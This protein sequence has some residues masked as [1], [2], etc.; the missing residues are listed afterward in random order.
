ML[1]IPTYRRHDAH[2]IC[3]MNVFIPKIVRPLACSSGLVRFILL[4]VYFFNS[5]IRYICSPWQTPH[6]RFERIDF[7]RDYEISTYQFNV[8]AV[9]FF[10][11]RII[12]ATVF[13]G[14]GLEFPLTSV[15]P[16]SLRSA[17]S[18]SSNPL[19]SSVNTW[20]S[21]TLGSECRGKSELFFCG[22]RGQSI[23][24]KSI[25]SCQ[26]ARTAQAGMSRCFCFLFF[27]LNFPL[28]EGSFCLGIVVSFQTRLNF[29]ILYKE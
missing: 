28:V 8:S 7:C 14:T 9:C 18:S 2:N 11:S 10:L 20:P 29:I 15:W 12:W 1:S 6:Q 13:F 21:S 25:D 16:C 5:F 24:K 4:F 27:F 19:S 23:C 3:H 22:N 26:P 17:R